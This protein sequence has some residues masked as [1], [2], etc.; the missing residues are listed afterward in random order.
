MM[1]TTKIDDP[2]LTE[3]ACCCFLRHIYQYNAN[4]SRQN[5]EIKT[6]IDNPQVHKY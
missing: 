2:K 4:K 1:T 3:E 5:S 6:R